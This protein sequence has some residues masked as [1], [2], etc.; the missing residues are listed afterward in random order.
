MPDYV[1]HFQA[2]LPSVGGAP[3]D[4]VVNTFTCSGFT[5]TIDEGQTVAAAFIDDV[6][7]Y[8]DAIGHWLNE[9]V[10][11]AALACKIEGRQVNLATGDLGALVAA[12]EFTL[13]APIDTTAWPREVAIVS[14]FHGEL[15]GVAEDVPAGPPGPEGNIHPAARRR[16]RRY[17]G[18]LAAGALG[19]G[20]VERSQGVPAPGPDLINDIVAAEI[21]FANN[22]GP[23]VWS[24]AGHEAVDVVGGWVDNEFDIQRRRG[25]KSTA[26]TSW[27]P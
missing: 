13:V 26:R 2:T 18:P 4:A 9:S 6:A 5:S 21:A 1:I 12:L 15:G 17:I 10:S 24:R 16:G 23:V 14:S 19:D 22:A 20:W 8:Y 11:R 27:V 3:E 25:Q 7:D